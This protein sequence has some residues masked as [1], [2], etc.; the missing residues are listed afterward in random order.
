MT[1]GNCKIANTTV[2]H[3]KDCYADRYYFE[4]VACSEQAAEARNERFFEERGD[5]EPEPMTLAA[6]FG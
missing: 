1:C 4:E 2:A 6:Y 3:V 5:T